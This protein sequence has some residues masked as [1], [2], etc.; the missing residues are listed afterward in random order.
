MVFSRTESSALSLKT[1]IDTS[2]RACGRL[3]K[4][5]RVVELIGNFF[6]IHKMGQKRLLN[7]T[8]LTKPKH[9][10]WCAKLGLFFFF[11]ANETKK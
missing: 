10:P 6:L 7:A 4:K 2:W 1:I 9:P 5:N 3:L 11:F 8:I